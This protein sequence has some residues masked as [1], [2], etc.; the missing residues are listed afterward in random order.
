MNDTS[1][2]VYDSEYPFLGI[3]TMIALPLCSAVLLPF[4]L[5][6]FNDFPILVSIFALLLLV[7]IFGAYT[8]KIVV[9]RDRFTI[10]T[11]RLI[12][13]MRKRQTFLFS[14]VQSIEAYLPLTQGEDFYQN[15]RDLTNG[16]LSSGR[17]KQNSLIIRYRDGVEVKLNPSI[18]RKAFR[19]ALGH[20]GKL[21]AI[22]IQ[23]TDKEA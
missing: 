18:Y 22:K 13:A 10:V 2:V 3:L 7:I 16:P 17:T 1:Q 12:P 14:Q 5:T 15:E 6:R 23:A 8:Q 21:S 4:V 11:W 20:I 9:E 19:E